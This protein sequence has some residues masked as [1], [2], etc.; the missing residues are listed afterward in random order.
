LRAAEIV[1]YH[2]FSITKDVGARLAFQFTDQ[3]SVGQNLLHGRSFAANQLGLIG[4]MSYAGLV[5]TLGY[6]NTLR[7]DDM[8]S[9]WSSYSGYTAAQVQD[10]DRAKEQALITKLSFDFSHLGLEG[11]T[12]YALFV[13]AWGRVN[14]SN[15]TTVPNENEFDADLQWHPNWSLLKGLSVRLRYAR[16]HQYQGPKDTQSDYRIILNYDW[17]L[18]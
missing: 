9:P 13:H 3:R 18:L 7:Q 17:S 12:A 14:P 10:F 1:D 16:V 6:T 8:Q 2:T 4:N 5:F 11:V 15:K